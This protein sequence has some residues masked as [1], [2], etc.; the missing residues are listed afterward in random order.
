MTTEAHFPL[1]SPEQ[2]G[3]AG[4]DGGAGGAGGAIAVLCAGG[5]ECNR[6]GGECLHALRA[7]D[8]CGGVRMRKGDKPI[9][10][11]NVLLRL[12]HKRFGCVGFLRRAE[13]GEEAVGC[14]LCLGACGECGGEVAG[15]FFQ[16][17]LI[18]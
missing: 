10:R 7:E 18:I 9:D 14:R 12:A 4:E 3:F 17:C 1:F 15:F 16:K 5:G 11:L 2:V 8:A 13:R 6:V